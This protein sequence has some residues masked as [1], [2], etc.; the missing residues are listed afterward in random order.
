MATKRLPQVNAL[1]E[2][3]IA[4]IILRDIELPKGIFVTILAV[5]TSGDLKHARLVVSIFPPEKRGT[6]FAL[7]RKR[8]PHIV[9]LLHERVRL[10]HIPDLSWTVDTTEDKAAEVEALLDSIK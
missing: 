3:A 6:A 1:L 5:T 10:R 8:T 2:R 7:L 4:E 9:S